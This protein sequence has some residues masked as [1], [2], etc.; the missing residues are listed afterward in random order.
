MVFRSFGCTL[1]LRDPQA[2]KSE[3]SLRTSTV[4][5]TQAV[6]SQ[7]GDFLN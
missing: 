7:I 1:T 6:H 5:T 3:L 2:T 4:N